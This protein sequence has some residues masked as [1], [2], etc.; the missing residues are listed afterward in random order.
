M[1]YKF[2]GCTDI[3]SDINP[4][5]TCAYCGNKSQFDEG[6]TTN[7]LFFCCK[8]NNALMFYFKRELI[9]LNEVL[10]YRW[11]NSLDSS[12]LIELDNPLAL[13]EC[14]DRDF[15]VIERLQQIA[16]NSGNPEFTLINR[17]DKDSHG[18]LL[19]DMKNEKYV[20]FITWYGS[21]RLEQIYIIEDYRRKGLGKILFDYWVEHYGSKC[22]DG[23]FIINSPNY[24][25]K[26]QLIKWGYAKEENGNFIP[27]GFDIIISPGCLL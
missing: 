13:L 21:C 27:I 11:N 25:F 6:Y 14:Y 4:V 12:R 5:Y 18:L 26:S 20:G 22:P 9:P 10:D 1:H 23:E 7:G 15:L 3:T 17:D 16:K 2:E 24:Y 8:C 19:I